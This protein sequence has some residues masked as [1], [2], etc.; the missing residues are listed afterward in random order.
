MS[1]SILYHGFGGVGYRYESTSYQEGVLIFTVEKEPSTLCAVPLAT[2]LRW[3]GSA[4]CCD[5]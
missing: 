1:T 2:A 3:S 5:G 4:P